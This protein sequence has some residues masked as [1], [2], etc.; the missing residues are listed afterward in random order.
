MLLASS[1]FLVPNT[2]FIVELV[3]FLVVLGVLAK[4]VLPYLTRALD[5][6][7]HTIDRAISDAEDAKR[8][9]KELEE[10]HVKMLEQGRED[11][12]RLRDEAA[13]VGEQLRQDLQKKGEEDYQRMVSSATADIQASARKAAE[14][15]RAQVS[16]L[17]VS[18]VERVLR[19]G[20]T[21]ADQ[22]R[23]IDQAIAEL[24]TLS[25]P[26]QVASAVSGGP[27]PGRGPGG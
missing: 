26:E 3:I 4:Y 15:L 22:Q 18:V 17:V 27:E 23:L 9:A 1:N 16:D 21:L 13:K 2:T 14:D 7:Q 11:A 25:S 5:E 12:R 19:E 10:E 8:R 20:V 6:R 24:E